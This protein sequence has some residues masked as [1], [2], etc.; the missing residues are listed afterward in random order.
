MQSEEAPM[1]QM[2]WILSMHCVF[3]LQVRRDL[4]L[5]KKKLSDGVL[6]RVFSHMDD[7]NN[8]SV[9]LEVHDF[10]FLNQLTPSEECAPSLS[11]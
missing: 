1:L 8:G 7:D 2:Y 9:E 11:Q 3:S 5:S 10:F 4:H 6:M